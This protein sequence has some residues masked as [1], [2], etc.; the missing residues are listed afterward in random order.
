L[1]D[2]GNEAAQIDVASHG[3]QISKGGSHSGN[4]PSFYRL[5]SF[6]LAELHDLALADE[7]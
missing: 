5:P 1:R 2:L 7:T 3:K 4:P 6:R